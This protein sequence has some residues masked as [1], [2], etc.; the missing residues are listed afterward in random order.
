MTFF[1]LKVARR[2]TFHSSAVNDGRTCDVVAKSVSD[3]LHETPNLQRWLSRWTPSL[4][5]AAAVAAANVGP[6]H[7]AKGAK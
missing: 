3:K 7:F 1:K 5:A 6:A 2:H 4:V